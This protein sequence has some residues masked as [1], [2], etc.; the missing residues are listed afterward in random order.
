MAA[1]LEA[2][3]ACVSL[4]R[5]E[6]GNRGN[7]G[8]CSDAETGGKK[9]KMNGE[10]SWRSTYFRHQNLIILAPR[11][12]R[13]WVGMP[14]AMGELGL[15]VKVLRLDVV[16][17]SELVSYSIQMDTNTIYYNHM[18]FYSVHY[19]TWSLQHVGFFFCSQ[20]QHLLLDIRVVN[21][22]HPFLVILGMIRCLNYLARSHS[23]TDFRDLQGS[24]W[25]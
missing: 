12:R 9:Q 4:P 17:A 11:Q 13:S 18:I 5:K 15:W 3:I 14:R 21:R 10:E 25:D 8:N 23:F 22:Y 2:G 20:A 7:R 1:T 16:P 19:Y 6:V 24:F